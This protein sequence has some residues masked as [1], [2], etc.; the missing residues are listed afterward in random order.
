M[1]LGPP[2]Q[3]G[4]FGMGFLAGIILT[5]TLA[6]IYWKRRLKAREMNNRSRRARSASIFRRKSRMRDLEEDLKE[7]TQSRG[8]R[9][10]R[11][12]WPSWPTMTWPTATQPAIPQPQTVQAPT[13]TLLPN[14]QGVLIQNQA[15]PFQAPAQSQG[16]HPSMSFS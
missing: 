6:W 11:P 3:G 5:I 1:E 13:Q 12:S 9:W 8:W 15:H 10:P 7:P 14:G 2:P 4:S 16:G